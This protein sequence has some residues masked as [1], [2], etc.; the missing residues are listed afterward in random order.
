MAAARIELGLLIT[1]QF[2]FLLRFFKRIPIVM[3]GTPS[4]HNL[5]SQASRS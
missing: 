2:V 4:Q 5:Y 3:Y 1:S